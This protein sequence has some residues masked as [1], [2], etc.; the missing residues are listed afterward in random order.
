MNTIK[1]LIEENRQRPQDN[2]KTTGVRDWHEQNLKKV[3]KNQKLGN[4][5]DGGRYY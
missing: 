1:R 5:V 2:F 4:S 3:K